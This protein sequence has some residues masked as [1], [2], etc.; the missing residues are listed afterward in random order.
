MYEVQCLDDIQGGYGRHKPYFAYS[1]VDKTDI[2]QV[3]KRLRL[4]SR[5][6]KDRMLLTCGDH[7]I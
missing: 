1:L 5:W 4:V 2:N 7:G 3:V 6:E